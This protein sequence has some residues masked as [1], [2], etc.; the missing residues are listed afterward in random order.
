MYTSIHV[1]YPLRLILMR[2]EFSRQVLEKSSNI[3]YHENHP[4][5]AELF[6]VDRQMDVRTD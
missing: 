3:E 5:G 6:H 2:L 1:D 4:M